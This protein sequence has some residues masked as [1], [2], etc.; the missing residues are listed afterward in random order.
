MAATKKRT[1]PVAA[2]VAWSCTASVIARTRATPIEVFVVNDTEPKWYVAIAERSAVPSVSLASPIMNSWPI[3][4][5]SVR[6]PRVWVTHVDAC[7]PLDEGV[8]TCVA[9]AFGP[10]AVGDGFTDA[11]AAVEGSTT[12]CD[13]EPATAPVEPDPPQPATIAATRTRTDIRMACDLRTRSASRSSRRRGSS[14][15]GSLHSARSGSRSPG[16]GS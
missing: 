2:D 5:A 8:G 12:D 7:V 6:P 10:V 9:G 16:S 15:S 13:G 4:C 11:E 3:R 1:P 14:A